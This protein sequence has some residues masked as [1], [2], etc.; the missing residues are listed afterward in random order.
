MTEKSK[1]R[2]RMPACCVMLGVCALLA[3]AA[4]AVAAVEPIRPPLAPRTEDASRGLALAPG[5]VKP[6]SRRS[7]REAEA[8]QKTLEQRRAEFE[9]LLKARHDRKAGASNPMKFLKDHNFQKACRQ[10]GMKPEEIEDLSEA[11][12]RTMEMNRR[13][14]QAYGRSLRRRE[15]DAK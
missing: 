4:V 11:L 10:K 15:G 1:D 9:K 13:A 5:T 8:S 2:S 3:S 12:V 6:M 14:L 7:V